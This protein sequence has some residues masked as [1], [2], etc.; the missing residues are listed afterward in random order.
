MDSVNGL[1]PSLQTSRT[2]LGENSDQMV[3]G[4]SCCAST[5]SSLSSAQNKHNRKGTIFFFIISLLPQKIDHKKKSWNKTRGKHGGRE[6]IGICSK[7]WLWITFRLLWLDKS[8]TGPVL[9]GSG[10]LE[11]NR[12]RQRSDQVR[13]FHTCKSPAETLRG[14]VELI[15]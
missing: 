4:S 7:A 13:S 6:I 15:K 11:E 8:N 1:L 10:T 3:F 2:E 9:K 12:S 5:E 14:L